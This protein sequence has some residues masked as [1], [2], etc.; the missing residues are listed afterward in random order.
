ML[1]ILARMI[2]QL[3][4]VACPNH[5]AS[6]DVYTLLSIFKSA[7]VDADLILVSQDLFGF[8][9]SIDQDRFIGA[10]F[11][12]L[13]FLRPNMN[14]SNN[15]VFS[16]Y[17]G[18]TN[19]PGDIIKGRAFRRLNVTRKI[20]VKDVLDLLKSA[21][22]MQMFALG[23]KCI[24]QCRGSPVGSLLSPALCLMVVSI[25]EQI[26]SINFKQILGNHLFI[27]HIRYVDNLLIFGDSRLQ[28]L[29]LGGFRN[30]E[31]RTISYQILIQHQNLQT[32]GQNKVTASIVSS[33]IHRVLVI[34]F[35]CFS[36]FSPFSFSSLAQTRSIAF[37]LFAFLWVFL[38]MDHAQSREFH[39]H[40]ARAIM[41][42]NC[43]AGFLPFFEPAIDW[44][45]PIATST[46]LLLY[47]PRH[48]SRQWHPT[49][50]FPPT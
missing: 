37:I 29:P 38:I 39:Y 22:N 2:F 8:F 35:L 12:L 14:V 45:D 18:Q 31:L 1:N 19:N 6:G 34:V 26:W 47:R 36:V 30:E 21:L 11:M 3:V 25:S 20:T 27:K 5:F 7:P 44:D 16:V 28:D 32:R 17:P 10:W 9:T 24:R 23:Q 48:Q 33:A 50:V 46:H 4:P 42:L 40:L 43:I 15:E 41:H 49:V 13:D